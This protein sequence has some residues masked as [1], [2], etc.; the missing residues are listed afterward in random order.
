MHQGGRRQGAPR[1]AA[2]IY[3]E[4][5]EARPLPGLGPDDAIARWSPDGRAIWVWRRPGLAI[6]RVGVTGQ[7]AIPQRARVAAAIDARERRIRDG[8]ALQDRFVRAVTADQDAWST[9]P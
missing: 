6:E 7:H 9:C 8:E 1:S 3:E 5:S 4:S 2:I